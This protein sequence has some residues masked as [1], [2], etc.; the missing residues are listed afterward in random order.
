MRVEREQWANRPFSR[1]MVICDDN[2]PPS[3]TQEM[4]VTRKEPLIDSNNSGAIKHSLKS[5]TKVSI[6]IIEMQKG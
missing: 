6:S 2:N 4:M 5:K 3:K 1:T